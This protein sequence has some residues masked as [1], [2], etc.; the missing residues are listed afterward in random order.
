MFT[1]VVRELGALDDDCR[2][3]GA[4]V[5]LKVLSCLAPDGAADAGR[6]VVRLKH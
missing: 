6:R 3:D 4:S 1:C 2:A 5:S